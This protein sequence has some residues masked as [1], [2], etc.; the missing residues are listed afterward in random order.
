MADKPTNKGKTS[1]PTTRTGQ[2]ARRLVQA[3]MEKAHEERRQEMFRRRL[4]LARLGVR[5][6]QQKRPGEAARAFHA[7]LQILEEW[8]GVPSGGLAPGLFDLKNDLPEL[9]LITG[10]Y[11]DLVKLYDRTITEGKQ[12][13]F[14]HYLEKF[15]LF[16]KGMQ[17]EALSAETLRKYVSNEKPLHKEDFKNAYKMLTGSSCFV[18]TALMDVCDERT[19]PRLRTW[20]DEYLV[21]RA[22]G[23]KFIA[24]YGVNGPR[25]A[26]ASERWPDWMRRTAGA[27]LDIFARIART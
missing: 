23:R 4:D 6:Y 13:E 27:G 21:H 14:R 9:V 12:V 3:A 24:W 17:Y 18:A 11:W 20:R 1:A 15:V 19:V 25:I 22:W 8:K 5:N 2:S 26:A 10:V 16:S 7:Y